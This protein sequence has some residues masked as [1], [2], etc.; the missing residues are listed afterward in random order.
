MIENGWMDDALMIFWLKKLSSPLEKSLDEA[1]D[2]VST[3]F[4]NN[5]SDVVQHT[6]TIGSS[7]H[8]E[9]LGCQCCDNLSS[10]AA[11]WKQIWH[12]CENVVSRPLS[13]YDR[14]E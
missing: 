9:R 4:N 14:S 7:L 5:K 13:S 2:F 11:A 8:L 3:L 12:V 1:A 10:G 6:T